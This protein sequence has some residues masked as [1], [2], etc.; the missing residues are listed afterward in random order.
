MKKSIILSSV[1]FLFIFMTTGQASAQS[2]LGGSI[3]EEIAG[4]IQLYTITALDG[5]A[6]EFYDAAVAGSIYLNGISDSNL[7]AENG[8]VGGQYAETYVIV[9]AIQDQ[10][11]YGFGD[12]FVL[13][14]YYEPVLALWYDRWAFSSLAEEQYPGEITFFGFDSPVYTPRLEY[15]FSTFVGLQSS[16]NYTPVLTGPSSVAREQEAEYKLSG[17]C[18]QKQISDWK[19]TASQT[20]IVVSRGNDPGETWKGPMVVSGT[21]TVTVRQRPGGSPN[22]L[23]VP[24]TVNPRTTGFFFNAAID[25]QVPNGFI[26][27]TNCTLTVPNPPS[28]ANEAAGR[29]ILR[30]RFSFTPND[31]TT[32]PNNGFKYVRS[33]MNFTSPSQTDDTAYFWTIARDADDPASTFYNAQCNTYNEQTNPT[34][35]IS[36]AQFRANVASH[37]SGPVNS[38][39]SFYITAQ[40]DPA[41]NV[42]AGAEGQIGPPSESI[43]D[44]RT[45]ITNLL[46]GRQNVILSSTQVEPCM[47]NPLCS[48]PPAGIGGGCDSTCTFRGYLNVSPYVTCPPR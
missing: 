6:Y 16:C 47:A 21:V 18:R 37:E 11:Y 32:G 26:C 9:G 33:I 31:V 28:M 34:G 30:Q 27:G 46:G 5:A 42:G 8:S 25:E 19:F 3:I 4:N 17:L 22:N 45:R 44:F 7:I 23:A 14:Y 1:L 20:G 13:C 40:N 29:F 48:N 15:V 36:G 24:T 10:D 38:H 12:H 2:I 43:P 39:Y 35:F 41:N